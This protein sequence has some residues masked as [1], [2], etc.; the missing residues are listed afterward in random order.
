MVMEVPAAE[1][2][3]RLLSIV[4]ALMLL[5]PPSQIV[6]GELPKSLQRN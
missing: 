2:E 1:D 6:Q 5:L 3:L 4:I